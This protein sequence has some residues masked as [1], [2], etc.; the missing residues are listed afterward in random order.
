MAVLSRLRGG[1]TTPA[2]IVDAIYEKLDPRLKRAAAFSV[3]AH[4]EDLLARGK[5]VC[6]TASAEDMLVTRWHAS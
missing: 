1:D 4:L 2:E 3:L 5:V 6:E